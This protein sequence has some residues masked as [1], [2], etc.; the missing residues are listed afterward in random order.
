MHRTI[1]QPSKYVRVS[2]THG[3]HIDKSQASHLQELL[4]GQ[5]H[6]LYVAEQQLVK[7][8]NLIAIVITLMLVSALVV[9][10]AEQ[11]R[12][13]SS[14]NHYQLLLAQTEEVTLYDKSNLTET[15]QERN[16]AIDYIHS[17]QGRLSEVTRERNVALGDSLPSKGTLEVNP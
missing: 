7:S 12:L 9:F 8:G 6:E 15:I 16:V 11:L 10:F 17:L 5:L 14:E 3:L 13:R 4:S 2:A 1:Q